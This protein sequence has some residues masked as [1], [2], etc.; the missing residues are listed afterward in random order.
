MTF[1]GVSHG[2]NSKQNMPLWFGQLLVCLCKG[3]AMATASRL[4][5]VA[6]KNSLGYL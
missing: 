1:L 3:V 2:V 4:M 5:F 6:K